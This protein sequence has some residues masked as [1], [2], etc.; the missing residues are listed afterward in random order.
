MDPC[1][2]SE[3]GSLLL[4]LSRLRLGRLE[5]PVAAGSCGAHPRGAK[6][7]LDKGPG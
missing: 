6:R 7:A 5:M 2:C 1:T 4:G 3:P